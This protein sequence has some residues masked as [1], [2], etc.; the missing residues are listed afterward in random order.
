MDKKKE[1]Q[2]KEPRNPSQEVKD[3]GGNEHGG[4]P[5]DV[6]FKKLLGCGG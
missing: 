2:E 4:F 6:D 1:E 5:E 3:H